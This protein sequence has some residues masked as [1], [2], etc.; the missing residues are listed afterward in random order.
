MDEEKKTDGVNQECER[1]CD[2]NDRD[3]D[4]EKIDNLVQEIAELEAKLS[5]AVADKERECGKAKDIN[6]MYLRLQADFDNYRKRTDDRLGKVKD[7]GIAEA[8]IGV[9]PTLDVIGQALQMITDDKIAEGVQMINRQLLG[10]LTSFGVSE[11]PALGKEFD[12][13]LHNAILQVPAD[14]PDSA[15]RVIEVFQ[16]GYRMGD[17]ILRHSVVKVAR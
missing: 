17:R 12:P 9:I 4:N 3:C 5:E 16:K 1:T 7:D 10:V 8:M 2:E 13:E 15:G 6:T 11:I 14:K